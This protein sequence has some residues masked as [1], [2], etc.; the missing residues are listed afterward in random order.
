[1]TDTTRTTTRTI[2]LTDR[3]PVTIRPELWPTIARASWWDSEYESQADRTATIRVREHA[4]GRRIV[5]G[6]A[7]SRWA[8]E[9]ESKAGVILA[10]VDGQADT[11]KTIRAIYDVADGIGYGDSR[12]V[13]ECIASLPAEAIDDER[14]TPYELHLIASCPGPSG[15]HGDPDKTARLLGTYES[16]DEAVA[17]GRRYLRDHPDAWIQ[18]CEP[19]AQGKD[20]EA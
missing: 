11:A 19:G 14:S 20:V 6:V 2:T 1:M 18:V 17:A 3:P 10:A 16:E 15:R 5:Y 8:G 12:L 13:A 4:D 7:T 9:G